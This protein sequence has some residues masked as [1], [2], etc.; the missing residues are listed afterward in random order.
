M[1][2]KLGLRIHLSTQANVSNVEALSFYS[3]LGARRIILARECGIKNI[4]KVAEYIKKKKVKCQVEAFI[5]GAMCVSISGRCFLSLHSFGK[6][7]NRGSCL[8]PCRREFFI[9]D[10]EN[11]TEY[12]LGKDYILS[13]KDLCTIDFIDK[14]IKSGIDAFKIEGRMRSPEYVK[15]VT[16][17]YRKAIDSYFNGEL[18]DSLKMNLK[19]QLYTVY[20]RGFSSGFYF[21]T[22]KQ[23]VSRYL[24]HSRKKVF[25]GEV[26]RFFGKISVA[27]IRLRHG[28][29]RA[30]DELLFIGKH[31][32]ARNTIAIEMQ[33]NHRFIKKAS[34][35]ESVGMKVPFKVRPKDKVFLWKEA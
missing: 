29:L 21:G 26:T 32:P 6:S 18:N 10:T 24:E 27:E 23:D 34:K 17:C 30:G 7:A 16:A 15:V 19:K 35:G 12:I 11:E 4:R 5:H 14:L 13:P 31:T 33:A 20:N 22:P 9:K 8:Q 1:A 2:K 3:R 28:S 25:L